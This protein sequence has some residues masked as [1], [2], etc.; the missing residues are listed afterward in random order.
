MKRIAMLALVTVLT[1]CA[2]IVSKTFLTTPL[3]ELK[4]NQTRA[5]TVISPGGEFCRGI[6]VSAEGHVL[7]STLLAPAPNVILLLSDG[8]SASVATT[9]AVDQASGLAL[10]KVGGPDSFSPPAWTPLLNTDPRPADDVYF[11]ALGNDNQGMIFRGY[12]RKVG[13]DPDEVLHLDRELPRDSF[14]TVTEKGLEA[15][16]GTPVFYSKNGMLA[17]MVVSSGVARFRSRLTGRT[18]AEDTIQINVPTKR[19]RDFLKKNR[20]PTLW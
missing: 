2:P 20:V 10:L 3:A 1:G 12:V 4:A 14:V 8:R 6:V 11:L 13:L 19:I 5:V 9:I 17:G 15:L 7:T 16:V 18:T